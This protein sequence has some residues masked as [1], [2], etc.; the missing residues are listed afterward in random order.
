MDGKLF[1]SMKAQSH[2]IAAK[3][4]QDIWLIQNTLTLEELEARANNLCI[5]AGVLA[6]HIARWRMLAGEDQH[7]ITSQKETSAS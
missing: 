5:A 7:G 2:E 1:N 4:M 3:I 6:G